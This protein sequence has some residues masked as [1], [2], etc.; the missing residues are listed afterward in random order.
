MRQQKKKVEKGAVLSS[1]ITIGEQL[2][3]KRVR[4]QHLAQKKKGKER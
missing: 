4:R 3:S 1:L 2:F